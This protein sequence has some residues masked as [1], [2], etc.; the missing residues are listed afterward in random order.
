VK[1]CSNICIGIG[2][3][4]FEFSNKTAFPNFGSNFSVLLPASHQLTS[5]NNKQ[6]NRTPYFNIISRVYSDTEEQSAIQLVPTESSTHSQA[7]SNTTFTAIMQDNKT[8]SWDSVL[9]LVLLHRTS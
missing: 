6:N 8:P 5:Q 2:I 1:H 9:L 7:V 4:T 3:D